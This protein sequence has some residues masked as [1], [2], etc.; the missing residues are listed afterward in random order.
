MLSAGLTI[1]AEGEDSLKKAVSGMLLALLLT[2][3]LAW[4][5]NVQPV[6]AQD[7]IIYIRADGS[8]DPPTAPIQ[9]D[10]NV[11]TFTDN[12]VN[13]SIVIERDSIVVD[14][15]GYTLQGIDIWNGIGINLAGRINVTIKNINI[16]QFYDGIWLQSSSSNHIYGN[17]I[18]NNGFSGI[19]LNSSSDN[20]ISGNDVAHNGD[21]FGD[22]ISLVSWSNYNSISGNNITDNRDGILLDFWSNHNSISGNNIANNDH[23][24]INFYDSSQYNSVVGNTITNHS[25]SGIGFMDSSNNSIIG[26]SIIGS[27]WSSHGI[28]LGSFSKYNSIIGNSITRNLYGIA[29]GGRSDYSS[30][31][32]NSITNNDNGISL[33]VFSHYNSISGNNITD[34]DNGIL[35][36]SCYGN[37][38]SGNNIA[39]ADYFLDYGIDLLS[40]SDNSIIGNTITNSDSGIRLR[41]SSNNNI[42]A[43]NI[44]ANGNDL[45]SVWLVSSSDN[46]IIGNNIAYNTNGIELDSSSDN[47]IIGNN[48][49][50]NIAYGMWLYDCSNNFIY[51]NNILENNAYQVLSLQSVNVWDDGY[52]SGGNY[53][54]DYTGV[55]LENGPNQDLYGSDGIGDTPYVIDTYNQDRYPLTPVRPATVVVSQIY[56]VQA[57]QINTSILVQINITNVIGMQGYVINMS[58]DPT[59]LRVTEVPSDVG[60]RPLYPSYGTTYYGLSRG[61]FLNT[62]SDNFGVREVNNTLGTIWY[63]WQIRSSGGGMSGSGVLVTINFTI[64]RLGTTKIELTS[65]ANAV[66][67]KDPNYDTTKSRLQNATDMTLIS[68]EEIEGVV[69]DLIPEFPPPL[70]LLLFMIAT[71]MAVIIRKRRRSI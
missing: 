21:I 46:S 54:S 17:N 42:S 57:D 19:S 5:L 35:L 32:G 52:P 39:C 45:F 25:F 4:A 7:G 12:I 18:T 24:G 62:G 9:H 37:S 61:S 26:N 6:R 49:T 63:L 44:T 50:Y 67:E 27:F 71:L 11:Y 60:V 29:I 68:H 28:S 8:V 64:L 22:G 14:G 59:I 13:D 58:W 41:W 40:S 30:I 23:Y 66:Y 53:W 36:D 20:S 47:S 69:S 16:R 70:V 55:D 38:I 31:S 33:G 1:L 56:N 65:P 2:G 48:I 10:G 51:H 43:N 3:M 15:A 34:N